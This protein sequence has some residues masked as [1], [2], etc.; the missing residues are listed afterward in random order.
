MND[1][2]FS[3]KS[4]RL[5]ALPII[6]EYIEKLGISDIFASHVH[7]DSRDLVPVWKT[8]GIVLRNVILERYP[9]YKIGEWA[10]LRGLI[11]HDEADLFNDDRIGRSLDRLYRSDRAAIGTSAVLNAIKQYD[12]EINRV[13]NDS[14]SVTLHGQ[15]DGYEGCDASMPK[16]GYNKDHRPDLKQLV[17]S[18]SVTSDFAVPLHFKVWDGNITDD[19]THIDNWKSLR[20]LIGNPKFTYVADSKLC[21]RDSMQYIAAEGGIFVTVLPETRKEIATFHDWMHTNN[22]E[23]TKAIDELNPRKKDGPRRTYWTFESPTLTVEGYRIVWVKSLLKQ[24]DDAQRRL[25]RIERTEEA[26][27]ALRKKVHKN[28][29]KLLSEIK[30]ILQDNRTKPYF[31]YRVVQCV[32]ESTKQMQRGR[33]TAD[34]PHRIIRRISYQIE[35]SQNAH[36]IQNDARYDG[37]FPLIT[38]SEEAAPSVLEIYKYQP[39][40]EKRHEQLKSVY[41]V[42][43]VFLQNPQRIESLLMI[44]FLAMLVASLV[45]RDARLKMQDEGVDAVPLYPENRKCKSPTTDLILEIFDDVRLQYVCKENR[46]VA[47]IPDTLSKKQLLVLKLLQIK[48][49]KFFMERLCI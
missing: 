9:L 12:I 17:F 16:Q 27:S 43:P 36:C 37:I 14:T 2:T 29:E 19:T 35:Y 7:A 38:N 11:K 10:Q 8:L 15:Y 18:L 23:W 26:F 6:D 45:E 13:H 33:P 3:I 31:E 49:A 34:T 41:N 28:E 22:P 24:L 47:T 32:D 20:T 21:V 42:A 40:L 1:T 30:T 4:I 46:S 39:N 25:T 48:P 44:Y 5:G